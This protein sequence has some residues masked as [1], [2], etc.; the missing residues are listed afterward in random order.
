[1]KSPCESVH[2]PVF[3]SKEKRIIL[4]RHTFYC[5]FQKIYREFFKFVMCQFLPS[6]TTITT[7]L[8]IMITMQKFLSFLWVLLEEE[9]DVDR[10]LARE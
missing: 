10:E 2:I 1:M 3:L 4:I 6:A 7:A 8:E 5:F 9:D